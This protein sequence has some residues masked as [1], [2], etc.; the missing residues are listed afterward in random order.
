M[1]GL[2]I[3]NDCLCLCLETTPAPR[4]PVC[5][6]GSR[7]ACPHTPCVPE[8]PPGSGCHLTQACTG[9]EARVK[10]VCYFIIRYACTLSLSTLRLNPCFSA[11]PCSSGC[12]PVIEHHV[13]GLHEL[14]SAQGE[15][16]RVSRSCNGLEERGKVMQ[17]GLGVRQHAALHS[18]V[19]IG[20]Q[21]QSAHPDQHTYMTPTSSNQVHL[22]WARG[23]QGDESCRKGQ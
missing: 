19:P 6:C 14:Q 8:A 21:R 3:A 18:A 15:Q 20:L 7:S 10:T 1:L 16:P 17:C 5:V 22:S 13:C 23:I 4:P 12:S 11:S 2:P 9:G